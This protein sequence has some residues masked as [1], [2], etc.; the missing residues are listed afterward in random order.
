MK[1]PARVTDWLFLYAAGAESGE[2][3]DVVVR[4]GHT[5]VERRIR[6]NAER[7]TR[8][9]CHPGIRAGQPVFAGTGHTFHDFGCAGVEGQRGGKH[10]TH[11]L[12][13]A[14]GQ[15]EAMAH[16]LAV[17]VDIGFGGECNVVDFFGGHG[18]G[19]FVQ[20]RVKTRAL[21]PWGWPARLSLCP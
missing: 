10:Y 15:C 5:D 4:L 1:K 7:L 2:V 8:L 16:T 17:E 19:V 6:G 18:Q 20:I 21:R 14:V 11:T 12:L 13:G 9:G 3:A